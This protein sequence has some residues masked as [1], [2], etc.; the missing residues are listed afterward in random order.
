M[1]FCAA[2][3]TC[4]TVACSLDWACTSD[5]TPLSAW[6]TP[7][8]ACA[9]AEDAAAAAEEAAPWVAAAAELARP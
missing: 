5:L 6:H 3:F 4:P 7:D 8:V 1:L 9:T 2:A